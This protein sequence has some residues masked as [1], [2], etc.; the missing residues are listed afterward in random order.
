MKKPKGYVKYVADLKSKVTEKPQENL[1]PNYYRVK[2]D[3]IGSIIIKI[4][5]NQ[6][7]CSSC[8]LKEGTIVELVRLPGQF[9]DIMEIRVV[10]EDQYFNDFMEQYVGVFKHSPIPQ[11]ITLQICKDVLEECHYET[12]TKNNN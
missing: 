12:K 4:K 2:R 5:S 7:I 11:D 3:T 9:P 1:V 10:G 8:Q 6:A